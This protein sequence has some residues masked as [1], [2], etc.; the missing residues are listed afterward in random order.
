[1]C[2]MVDR[3]KRHG[4]KRLREQERVGNLFIWEG[5]RARGQKWKDKE[6]KGKKKDSPVHHEQFLLTLT[7]FNSHKEPVW[8]W[9]ELFSP[10]WTN[11]TDN[12]CVCEKESKRRTQIKTGRQKAHVGDGKE[13]ICVPERYLLHNIKII[14]IIIM[15]FQGKIKFKISEQ[16]F[17]FFTK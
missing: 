4:V 3:I 14:I 1:M 17:F 10:T 7:S 11:Q 16:N 8:N 9:Q 6:G 15:C 12:V 5:S 13:K 2:L